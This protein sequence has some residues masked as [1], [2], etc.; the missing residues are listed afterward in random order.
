MRI[1]ERAT[2]NPSGDVGDVDEERRADGVRRKRGCTAASAADGGLG[3]RERTKLRELDRDGLDARVV[4][5]KG[6]VKRAI[7]TVE[8]KKM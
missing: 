6:T 1:A 7:A 2:G 5:V 4:E 8:R 3:V